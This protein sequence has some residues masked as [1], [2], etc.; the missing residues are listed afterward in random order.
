MGRVRRP[1]SKKGRTACN[2]VSSVGRVGELFSLHHR[3]EPMDKG[4]LREP[5]ARGEKHTRISNLSRTG[6][7]ATGGGYSIRQG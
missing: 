4:C 2:I 3:H 6:Q 7:P 1:T 5:Y